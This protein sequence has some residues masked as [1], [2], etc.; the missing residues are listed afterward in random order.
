MII[1]QD[2]TTM[3]AGDDTEE[4][5]AEGAADSGTTDEA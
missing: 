2:D 1:M 3:P 4:N 5:V